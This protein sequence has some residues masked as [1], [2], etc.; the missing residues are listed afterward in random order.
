M[1]AR[2]PL[3][4][5]QWREW[6]SDEVKA[7]KGKPS[8]RAKIVGALFERAVNDYLSV[9]L[10]LGPAPPPYLRPWS[11]CLKRPLLVRET[12]RLSSS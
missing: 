8:R 12:L 9:P 3:N 1:S 5:S 4:E 10:W 7:T 2:F 11:L 6:I